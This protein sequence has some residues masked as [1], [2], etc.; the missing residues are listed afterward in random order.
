MVSETT[1]IGDTNGSNPWA[2]IAAVEPA[3]DLIDANNAV[4]EEQTD[5]GV[6]NKPHMIFSDEADFESDSFTSRLDDGRDDT[7]EKLQASS[8]LDDSFP[9]FAPYAENG[10]V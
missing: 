8:T 2:E 6:R 10:A 7:T 9:D 5:G 4:E 3:A 1:E